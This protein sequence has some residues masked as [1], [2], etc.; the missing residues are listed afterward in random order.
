MLDLDT[1]TLKGGT[2]CPH[3]VLN[4]SLSDQTVGDHGLPSGLNRSGYEVLNLDDRALVAPRPI[5][6][7]SP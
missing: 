2:R 6:L 1:G 7:S 3:R 5:V 4:R